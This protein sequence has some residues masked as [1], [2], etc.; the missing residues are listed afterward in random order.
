[1][2]RLRVPMVT[3]HLLMENCEETLR[4]LNTTPLKKELLEIR[5]ALKSVYFTLPVSRKTR[6]LHPLELRDY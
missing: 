4:W 2:D 1:M 6:K 5:K 3:D